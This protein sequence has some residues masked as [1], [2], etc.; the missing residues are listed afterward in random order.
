MKK[1]LLLLVALVAII[2]VSW[3]LINRQESRSQK[4]FNFE[5]REF[6]YKDL[7]DIGKIVVTRRYDVPKVFTREKDHWILNDTFRV[8][9]NVMDNMLDAIKN[10]RIDYVP[11]NSATE[12][13]MKSFLRH[14]IKVELYNKNDKALKKYYVGS[15][16]ADGIGTYY[17]MEGYQNPLVMSLPSMKGSVHPRF[18]YTIEQW[19]DLTVLALEKES[20]ASVE[21]SY[22][23]NKK[24]SFRLDGQELN[25]LHPFQ[26]PIEGEPNKNMIDT[27]LSGFENLQAEYIENN[28]P[29]KDSILAQVP[30]CELRIM[31]K[32][33]DTKDLRFFY[34]TN[35]EFADTQISE[36]DTYNPYHAERF[37]IQ[38]SWNDV[39]LA[40]H[41]LFKDVFWK[42]DFF[43]RE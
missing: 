41:I 21:V 4:S 23:F 35:P 32:K 16:P 24:F 19:R 7:D 31:T 9:K 14:G 20:I 10:I 29:N 40:Q 17:V 27:Y 5:Y 13:I 25:P 3:W 8:R 36:M 39:Y 28:N 11:P 26:K 12:N 2:G 42:Y 34:V 18:N 22:P 33:G 30:F 15:S 37:L 38:T 1:N 43:F 6:A